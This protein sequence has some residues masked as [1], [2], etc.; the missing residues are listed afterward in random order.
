MARKVTAQCSLCNLCTSRCALVLICVKIR[1]VH[2]CDVNVHCAP[3]LCNTSLCECSVCTTVKIRGTHVT[4]LKIR[5]VHLCE[6]AVCTRVKIRGTHTGPVWM[7]TEHCSVWCTCVE[8]R[9]T[10]APK[11]AARVA[12]SRVTEPKIGSASTSTLHATQ[13]QWEFLVGT[14]YYVLYTIY[15]IHIQD[16]HI[17]DW[18]HNSTSRQYSASFWLMHPIMYCTS[19]IWSIGF[20]KAS[21]VMTAFLIMLRSPIWAL[22]THSTM[23][24]AI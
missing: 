10:H 12:S 17:Q 20:L 22:K 6:C 21:D 16:I 23:Q 14:N 4:H 8:I 19:Q 11:M 3:V 5:G 2:M 9:G 1:G 15:T 7:F 18:L 24:Y 13:H